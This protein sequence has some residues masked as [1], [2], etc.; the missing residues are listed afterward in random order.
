MAW[1]PRKVAANS[2]AP[3]PDSSHNAG[4]TESG[5][6]EC[7]ALL[8]IL[9]LYRHFRRR[10][11]AKSRTLGGDELIRFSHPPSTT[12]ATF[13]AAA[14]KRRLRTPTG[15]R[16]G[17]RAGARGMPAFAGGLKDFLLMLE[18]LNAAAGQTPRPAVKHLMSTLAGRAPHLR[19]YALLAAEPGEKGGLISRAPSGGF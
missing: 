15:S 1:Y 8:W 11:L 7:F 17:R 16:C 12:Q 6:L 3:A 13:F 4:G 5:S 10:R 9:K 14:D 19:A 2:K 18:P